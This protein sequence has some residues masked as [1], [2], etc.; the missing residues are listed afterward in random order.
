MGYISPLSLRRI[1]R[2]ARSALRGT[3]LAL[4]TLIFVLV[5]YVYLGLLRR[6]RGG[7]HL[8]VLFFVLIASWGWWFYLDHYGLLYSTQGIWRRVQERVQKIAP[9]LSLDSDPYASPH[10]AAFEQ[11]LNY[12]RNSVKVVMDMYDGTMEMYDGTVR[13]YVM[14]PEDP[15][16]AFY[17]RAFPGVFMDLSQLSADLKMHLRYPEDLFSIQADMYRSFHVRYRRSSI[18]GR[19]SGCSPGRNTQALSRPCRPITS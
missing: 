6:G 10:S 7:Q 16:L 9:F 11:E 14:D 15:V 19:T 3:G 12:V 13:F 5:F 17:R 1:L 2:I 4:I 8:S 18:T